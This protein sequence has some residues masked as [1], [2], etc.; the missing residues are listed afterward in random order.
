[1]GY[2]KQ[3]TQISQPSKIPR[4]CERSQQHNR[5]IVR[6]VER[7]DG[8]ARYL[9]RGCWWQ[10]CATEVRDAIKRQ[11]HNLFNLCPRLNR[12][13]GMIVDYLLARALLAAY[14]DRSYRIWIALARMAA[15]IAE[16]G[17]IWQ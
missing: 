2:L 17:A 15:R 4:R 11:F 3:S 9:C 7:L 13:G 16:K 6:H 1:L 5:A 12:A 14:R 8:P 10:T